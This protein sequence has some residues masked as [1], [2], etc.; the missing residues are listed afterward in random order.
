M[1][2]Q[3]VDVPTAGPPST[4]WNITRSRRPSHVHHHS[5]HH[6]NHTERRGGRRDYRRDHGGCR[7]SHS[8]NCRSGGGMGKGRV[9]LARWARSVAAREI[10]R[11][12]RTAGCFNLY[13]GD[14]GKSS[15]IGEGH[16]IFGWPLRLRHV[17][18]IIPGEHCRNSCWPPIAATHIFIF[19]VCWSLASTCFSCWCLFTRLHICL[20]T[21][22][23]SSIFAS[24][25]LRFHYW[26]RTI[27]SWGYRG[28]RE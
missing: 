25:L 17:R 10:W 6:R 27:W 1:L 5:Y 2:Q 24:H 4:Q 23:F 21:S 15:K 11:W 18:P 7:G 3:Q 20:K 9:K 14:H 12:P 13:G 16:G 8:C 28:I 19:L 26:L 22:H